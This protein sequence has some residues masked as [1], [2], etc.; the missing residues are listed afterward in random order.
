MVTRGGIF[1]GPSVSAGAYRCGYWGENVPSAQPVAW[2]FVPPGRVPVGARVSPLPLNPPFRRVPVVNSQPV[3]SWSSEWERP[4]AAVSL[5]GSPE[6]LDPMRIVVNRGRRIWPGPGAAQAEWPDG[7]TP[8]GGVLDGNTLSGRR[9]SMQDNY[10][11]YFDS[12][13]PQVMLPTESVE[14][15]PESWPGED[16][17]DTGWGLG[18]TP[19]PRVPNAIRRGPPVVFR[20]HG[21]YGP[22]GTEAAAKPIGLRRAAVPETTPQPLARSIFGGAVPG[23][24]QLARSTL[25]TPVYGGSLNIPFRNTID[26]TVRAVPATATMAALSAF[27]VGPDGL[28]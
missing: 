5:A 26:P 28:G 14:F 10:A 24:R 13:S 8:R 2:P 27:G 11:A 25:G 9:T 3:P 21:D 23:G 15:L 20:A 7:M 6:L 18:A 16:V 1:E 12:S 22:T 4:T 17:P 19:T